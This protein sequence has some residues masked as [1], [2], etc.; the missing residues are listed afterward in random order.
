M[1]KKIK[2]GFF[3]DGQWA[4]NSAKN[5]LKTQKN[6]RKGLGELKLG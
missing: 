1:V 2:I 4:Y 5:L 3:G 6:F